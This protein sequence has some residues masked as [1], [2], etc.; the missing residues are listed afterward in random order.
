M[1]LLQLLKMDARIIGHPGEIPGTS[2]IQQWGVG[3]LLLKGFEP[4]EV[5]LT[6]DVPVN[7]DSLNYGK[8]YD[9]VIGS[10]GSLYDI[11]L[12]NKEK[13]R[14]NIRACYEHHEGFFPQ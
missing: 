2:R 7:A 13:C 8:H 6:R 9:S 14:L 10:F 3:S 5:P 12:L 1:N 11:N 4:T